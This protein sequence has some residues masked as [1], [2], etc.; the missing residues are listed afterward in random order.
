[1][2]RRDHLQDLDVDRKVILDWILEK[3]VGEVWTGFMRL[4]IGPEINLRLQ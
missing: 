3:E 1:M 2:K 4:R